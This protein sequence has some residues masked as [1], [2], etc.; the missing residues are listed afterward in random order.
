MVNPDLGARLQGIGAI[1]FVTV[2]PLVI[3]HHCA[4][5]GRGDGDHGL[6][7]AGRSGIDGFQCGLN[8]C[9]A[10]RHIV[11]LR[12]GQIGRRFHRHCLPLDIQ[13]QFVGLAL[14]GSQIGIA[15]AHQASKCLSLVTCTVSARVQSRINGMA[16]FLGQDKFNGFVAG[17]RLE[18]FGIEEDDS[19][20]LD[21]SFGK[22]TKRILHFGRTEQLHPNRAAALGDV[23]KQSIKRDQPL[24]RWQRVG[25]S[26][27]EDLIELG[28]GIGLLQKVGNQLT[29]VGLRLRQNSGHSRFSHTEQVFKCRSLVVRI[30]IAWVQVLHG[31]GHFGDSGPVEHE[32]WLQSH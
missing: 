31:V 13:G 26:S 21:A 22:S 6:D 7:V 24:L 11:R 5:T 8:I 16:K 17:T 20:T 4:V 29:G 19:V 10:H 30:P 18:P 12:N 14:S 32:A 23:R 2:F 15:V 27:V 28:L 25:T 9:F 3:D 1:R